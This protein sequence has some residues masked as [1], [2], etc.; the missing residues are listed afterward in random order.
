[1][2]GDDF[3]GLRKLQQAVEN[4]F[5]AGVVMYDGEAVVPFGNQLYAVPI[6]GLWEK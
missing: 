3:K 4:R 5:V 2:T 6:S 1:M